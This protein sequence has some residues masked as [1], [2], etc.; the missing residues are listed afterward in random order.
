MDED[1]RIRRE[2]P[3]Q[4]VHYD[5]KCHQTTTTTTAKATRRTTTTAGSVGILPCFSFGLGS[6]DGDDSLEM[7]HPVVQRIQVLILSDL[8]AYPTQ[9]DLNFTR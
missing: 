7:L 1:L 9:Q 4:V 2:G 3:K 5:R 6:S 8:D